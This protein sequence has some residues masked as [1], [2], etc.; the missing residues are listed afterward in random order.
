MKLLILGASGG[1]GNWLTRLAAQAGHDVTAMVRPGTPF[2]APTGVRVIRG[3]VLDPRALASALEGQGAVASCLGLRRRS[4]LP[5]AP[6][7][8][9]PDLTTNIARLLS[10]I[11]PQAGVR[12]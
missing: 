1:V 3:N 9:P 6:L 10:T 8:S 5:W 7:L 11:M 2:E 4:K 12:R